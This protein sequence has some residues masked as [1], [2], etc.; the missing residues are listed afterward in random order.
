M[1]NVW[2]T[3]VAGAAAAVLALTATVRADT[4]IQGAGATFP[5]PLYAK[6]VE[7]YNKLHPDVKIDYQAVGS[8]GGIKGITDRTVNFGASD[9]PMSADQEK[10]APGAL[11]HLPTVAGPEVMI[12]NLP[13]VE[14]VNLSGEVIADIYLKKIRMWNDPKIAALNSGV[15]L[16]ASPVVVVH[17]SDGSGTTYIFTDY[18]SKVSPEW[19]DK[20]GKGTAVEWVTGIAAKGNDGVTGAVKNTAGGLGYVEFAY[21][22][23]NNLTFASQINKD[24]KEAA[25]SIDGILAASSASL[26]RFPEDLK[27]SITNAPGANSYPICGFTYLKV[28]QDMSYMGDKNTAQNVVDFIKWCETDGQEMAA[29]QGYAKLPKEAQDKVLAK[30]KTISFN[31]EMLLK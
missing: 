15:N 17:R 13:G 30:L 22:K 9:A 12:Y 14:K 8:G 21:A 28:Y 27:V 4:R 29:E 1:L 5:A 7:A 11:L 23:K 20:V 31:G 2:K 24:G 25:P 3:C 18:L 19:M 26:T 16:P 10:A 6:W